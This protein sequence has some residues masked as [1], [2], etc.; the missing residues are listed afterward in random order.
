MFD[1]NS[2]LGGLN[3]LARGK[4]GEVSMKA[5]ERPEFPPISESPSFYETVDNMN[6]ADLGLFLMLTFGS[7]PFAHMISRRAM[8]GYAKQ[9]IIF[10]WVNT[11]S[12][13]TGVNLAFINSFRRLN[14]STENGLRWKYGNDYLRKYDMTSEYEGNTVWGWFNQN[15]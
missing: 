4:Y 10:N 9:A 15:K 6:Q 13:L 3:L 8:G 2:L 5:G 12:M 1:H 14:G 11:F 7:L